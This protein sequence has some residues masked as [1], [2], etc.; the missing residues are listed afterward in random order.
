[1]QRGA[2]GLSRRRQDR[3][4]RGRR[5]RA[6]TRPTSTCRSLPASC[7]RAPR[8]LP[9][10]SWSMSLAAPSTTAAMS[11]RR[12]LRACLSGALRLMAIAP[13]DL[14][15]R[16]FGRPSHARRSSHDGSRSRNGAELSPSHGCSA[17]SS[18]CRTMSRSATSR[19][20]AEPR[21]AGGSFLAVRGIK[22]HGLAVSRPGAR[23]RRACGRLGAGAG[24][25]GARGAPRT[26]VSLAVP[27]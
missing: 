9:R 21:A 5:R 17:A 15:P 10:W 18:K 22:S 19:S 13:D 25:R 20:T 2:H 24:R 26:V 14:P 11:R 6:A 7:R 23:R 8:A 27:S 16:N 12:C 4:P 3:A 1:M